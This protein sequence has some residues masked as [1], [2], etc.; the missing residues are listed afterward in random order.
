[1]N[2]GFAK[3]LTVTPLPDGK[4]WVLRDS[5]TY[6]DAYG[7]QYRVPS[8]FV[9]DFASIPRGP[10]SL[11][12]VLVTGALSLFQAAWF[13]WALLVLLLILLP[14]RYGKHGNAAALHDWLYWNQK[15]TRLAADE[16]FYDAMR[17][18]GVRP[19]RARLMLIA[20]RW[21][22]WWAW[23]CNQNDKD[24]G[25]VRVFVNGEREVQG[26]NLAKRLSRI[27]GRK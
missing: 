20:V 27:W 10:I 6:R 16:V 25:V 22:G 2:S 14:P 9:M 3:L 13:W 12:A 7:K 18:L 24:G 26:R 23:W 4:S 5:L 19:T 15:T 21:F 17:S 11:A 8:G 1:M